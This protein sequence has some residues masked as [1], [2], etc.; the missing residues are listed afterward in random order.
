[1]TTVGAWG[2]EVPVEVVVRVTGVPLVVPPTV[3]D[4]PVLG[5]LGMG[6]G[7]AHLDGAF[8][9][10][11]GHVLG[12]GEA[13]IEVA[14][15]E[16]P[17]GA[18]RPV[19]GQGDG[20]GRRVDCGRQSGQQGTVLACVADLGLCGAAG[21]VEGFACVGVGDG[22]CPRPVRALFDDQMFDDG[23]GHG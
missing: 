7:F 22:P 6:D 2:T 23:R 8:A 10:G 14:V 1:M 16:V 4:G 3:T 15:P 12:V 9:Y 21:E 11:V 19:D 13:E 17:Q 5:R 20:S 18:H